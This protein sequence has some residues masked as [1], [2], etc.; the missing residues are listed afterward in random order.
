MGSVSLGKLVEEMIDFCSHI[1]SHEIL[2]SNPG[3]HLRVRFQAADLDF[4]R[5]T[6]RFKMVAGWYTWL[7]L[8]MVCCMLSYNSGFTSLTEKFDLNLVKAYRYP[9]TI[10][11]AW[12]ENI[13]DD[14]WHLGCKLFLGN[15]DIL[16]DAKVT[17]KVFDLGEKN[18]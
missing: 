6:D 17:L 1:I 11:E 16:A 15:G 9:D 14:R 7:S 13:I 12:V 3:K 4:V 5:R 2:E 8:D 18:D 10:A